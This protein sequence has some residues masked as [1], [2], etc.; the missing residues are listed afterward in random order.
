MDR[1]VCFAPVEWEKVQNYID[2]LEEA[3]RRKE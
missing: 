1:S 3:L 2:K